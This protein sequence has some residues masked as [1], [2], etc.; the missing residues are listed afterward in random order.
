MAFCFG[1]LAACGT[2]TIDTVES[3]LVDLE[4]QPESA[5]AG[6]IVTM[7][8]GPFSEVRDT[9]LTI[10]GVI[11]PLLAI[12]PLSE[13]CDSCRT[14]RLQA[15]CGPCGTC[16]GR[17][18]T[19]SR[20]LACFGGSTTAPTP[21]TGDT[22]ED[23]TTE[24]RGFCDRCEERSTFEIPSTLTVG[25]TEAWLVNRFGTSPNVPFTVTP[26]TPSPSTGDTG[27][28]GSP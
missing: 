16:D 15:G 25:P 7:T 4:L 20:R 11:V 13:D 5:S 27:S 3:C 12:E 9:R 26:A 21:P 8:G 19:R 6:D 14:C 28:N 10:D 18:L 22:G 1:F 23:S 17:V 2:P 24:L